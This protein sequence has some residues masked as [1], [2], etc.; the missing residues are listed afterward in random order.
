[1]TAFESSQSFTIS[2]QGGML[3]TVVPFLPVYQ[4]IPVEVCANQEYALSRFAYVHSQDEQM[5]LESPLAHVKVILHDWRATALIHNL[6][7]QQSLRKLCNEFPSL[8]EN[9]VSMFLSFLLSGNFLT[10]IDESG[11]L[12]EEH[13]LTQWDF[14]DLL[15]HARSRLGRHNNPYG[16]RDSHRNNFES[17]PAIKSLMSDEV[18]PLYKPDLQ[19]LLDNDVPFTRVIEERRS[20]RQYGKLP[21]T[22]EQLGEFLYR[23]ARLRAQKRKEQVA[24]EFSDRPYPSGGACYELELYVVIDACQGIESGLYHYCPRDHTLCYLKDHTNDVIKLSYQASTHQGLPQVLIILAARFPRVTWKYCS[25][26]YA[27]ILK[28]VGVLYQSMYLV[29]TA[30]GLAPCAIGGGDSDLF[31]QA[32]G[33]DYYVETSVGEFILGSRAD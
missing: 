18:I 12:Q 11:K 25:L 24:Y 13:S 22:I 29:A 23:T 3:A 14:H 30:M 8:S 10:V 17:L 28:H 32:I 2:F 15:F 7:Q 27:L 5:V 33:T 21:I 31:A 16:Q 9:S 6:A 26:T 4:L 19:A 1:M 20:L